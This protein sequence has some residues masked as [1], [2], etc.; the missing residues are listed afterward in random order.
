G[1]GAAAPRAAP[2]PA[3]VARP[4]SDR[5]ARVIDADLG[6]ADLALLFDDDAFGA[7]RHRLRDE[8]V[9]VERLAA[10]REVEVAALRGPPIDRQPAE[11]LRAALHERRAGR[12]EDVVERDELRHRL[13]GLLA[14]IEGDLLLAE[15]LVVLVPLAPDQ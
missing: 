12:G 15:N 9:P 11:A 7:R 14:D 13:G 4:P 5:D 10:D 2:A 6:A 8:G 3:Q 1:A